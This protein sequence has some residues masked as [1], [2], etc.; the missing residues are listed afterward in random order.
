MVWLALAL[1]ALAAMAPLALTLRRDAVAR[2]QREAA[3]ELHRAQLSELDRD[4]A[5]GRIATA[6][7]ANAVVEVQ[8]RLL[9]AAA[10]HETASPRT[11]RGPLVAALLLVPL[12]GFAL[13]IAGGS[14]FL[15][16]AP[17]AERISR[18][19]AQ[20]REAT[21]LVTQLRAR[22]A[23]LDPTTEQARQ[24]YMLLGNAEAS[25]G[26]MPAAAQAWR[27]ALGARFDPT[28]AVQTAEAIT[29]GQGRVTEEAAALFRR[30]LAEAP[31]DARW[32]PMAE[33]RLAQAAAGG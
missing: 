29:E 20:Q 15:P 32:R 33:K 14:P 30:A 16:A 17:L 3:I 2:G 26:N 9:A 8:R 6:E 22:L 24:G 1:L 28:L 19:E 4:L 31:P 10:A 7:H 12:A 13:Y 27:T 11:S 18:A 25:M 21:A 5:E 23:Q